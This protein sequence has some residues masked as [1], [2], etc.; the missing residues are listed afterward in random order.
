MRIL[1]LV[2]LVTGSLPAQSAPENPLATCRILYV[3]RPP[4]GAEVAAAESANQPLE[5]T[6]YYLAPSSEKMKPEFVP[7]FLPFSRLTS[8]VTLPA[9]ASLGLYSKPDPSAKFAEISPGGKMQVVAVLRASR[10]QSFRD[11]KVEILDTSG[12]GFPF[13][14]MRVINASDR[15]VAIK[16]LDPMKVVEA[17]GVLTFRPTPGRRDTVPVFAGVQVGGDWREIHSGATKVRANNRVLLLISGQTSPDGK[18]TYSVEYL[19]ESAPFAPP[20]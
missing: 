6:V 15:K 4:T 17:G 10:D 3:D 5:P 2:I 16:T 11:A 13:G 20:E 8:P 14:Q 7:L 9:G 1:L 18:P 12:T 19:P